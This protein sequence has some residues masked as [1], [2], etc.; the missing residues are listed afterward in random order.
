M[1]GRSELRVFVFWGEFVY[2][3]DF[4]G[5]TFGVTYM[6]VPRPPSYGMCVVGNGIGGGMHYGPSVIV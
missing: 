3:D 1:V 4:D 6:L 5:D 2:G